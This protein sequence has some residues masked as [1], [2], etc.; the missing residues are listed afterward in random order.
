MASEAATPSLRLTSPA[1]G[2]R[3][4]LVGRRGTLK[5]E[6]VVHNDGEEP[7]RL[8]EGELRGDGEFRLERLEAVEVAPGT[9]RTASVTAAVPPLT[10][11]GSYEAE[12]VVDGT[13]Q[14]VTLL[15]TD[16]I[17]LTLSEREIVV[18]AGEPRT[19]TMSMRNTGNVPLNVSHVGPVT[20]EADRPRPT[21]LQRLG[22]LPQEEPAADTPLA[23]ATVEMH[24]GTSDREEER[25]DA[26]PTVT[27]RL[28]PPV[29]VA[30]GETVLGDWVVTVDGELDPALRYR[31]TAPLYTADI[32]F[33]VTPAQ[34]GPPTRSRSRR[35]S[36]NRRKESP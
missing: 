3:P 23:A 8:G 36:A 14:A 17:A 10:P 7:L 27:A 29:T 25:E 18:I 32:E 2:G 19:K 6:L 35:T 31:A 34:H 20:L 21:L 22:V 1:P 15:I 24:A 16:D 12:I 13:T 11:P 28:D 9:A 5:G 4:L 30:P 26:L 33:V